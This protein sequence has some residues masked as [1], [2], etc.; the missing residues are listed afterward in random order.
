ML[1]ADNRVNL[2]ISRVGGWKFPIVRAHGH[3]FVKWDVY[4]ELYTRTELERL[5]VHFV[6]PSKQ[7]FLNL[8]KPCTPDCITTEM[9][10]VIHDIVDKC[11]SCMRFGLR[12]Y[13]LHVSLP[14]DE[15]FFNHEVTIDRFGSEIIRSFTSSILILVT[16]MWV[17]RRVCQRST[18]TGSLSKL[19]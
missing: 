3:M 1:V 18:C 5:D 19:G 10:R 14:G 17:Y 7:K 15:I 4:E 2:L 16:R 13:G 8:L 9:P 12:P 11:A 6:H